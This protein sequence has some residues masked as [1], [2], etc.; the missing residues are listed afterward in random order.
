MML[1]FFMILNI[2]VQKL[3]SQYLFRSLNN[4][5]YTI[6]RRQKLIV[7]REGKKKKKSVRLH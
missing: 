5:K 6:L 7:R 1:K 4:T 3:A 2:Y